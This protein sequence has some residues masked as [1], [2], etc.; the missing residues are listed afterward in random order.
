MFLRY[1]L[2]KKDS[3]SKI[4]TNSSPGLIRA[5]VRTYVRTYVRKR[6][7]NFLALMGL[8]ISM[9][10]D[11]PPAGAFGARGSFAKNNNFLTKKKHQQNNENAKIT[12]DGFDFRRLISITTN[13][14]DFF[15][16]GYVVRDATPLCLKYASAC[17]TNI[18]L[19]T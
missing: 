12:K 3:K 2:R 13:K 16:Q 5:C 11:A 15:F 4:K 8:L 9:P 17:K 19:G 18:L 14:L 7:P 1:F 6:Q 10:M